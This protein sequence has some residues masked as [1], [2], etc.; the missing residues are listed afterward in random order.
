VPPWWPIGSFWDW[1]KRLSAQ[2]CLPWPIILLL[3]LLALIIIVVIIIQIIRRSRGRSGP[4][5]KPG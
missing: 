2:C 5:T 1:I 4:K 3:A